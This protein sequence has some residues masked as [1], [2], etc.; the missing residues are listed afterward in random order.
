M[1][2]GLRSPSLAIAAGAREDIDR[3]FHARLEELADR[4]KELG[5]QKESDTTLAFV[6]PR[7]PQRSYYFYPGSMSWA[8]SR[9]GHAKQQ[10]I[11]FWWKHF[12]QAREE[13]AAALFEHAQAQVAIDPATTYAVLFEVCWLD[14]DH[15]A[16]RT[17]LGYTRDGDEWQRGAGRVSVT[18]GRIALKDYGF[19]AKQYW[20]ISS[21]H[22]SIVTNAGEKKGRELA[23]SLEQ[24]HMVWHQAFFDYWGHGPTLQRRLD[25]TLAPP[26]R[27]NPKRH[28]VVY[29][30]SREQYVARLSVMEPLIAK[31]IG[32][33][34][35]PRRSSYLYDATV[36]PVQAWRHEVGHQLFA[37]TLNARPQIGEMRDFWVV[38]GLALYLESY[39]PHGHYATL[40][41][42]VAA[43]LQFARYRAIREGFR[44]P[45]K[46][47]TAWGRSDV[48]GH[49]RL[50]AL[51]SQFAG[52]A[53]FMMDDASGAYRIPLIQYARDTYRNGEPNKT[54]VDYL[55]DAAQNLDAK[56]LEYLQVS[57]RLLSSA[58]RPK[59]LCLA[60]SPVT[61]QG[62]N[63]LDVSRLEW[64][65]LSD[66]ELG[67]EVVPLI[68]RAPLLEQLSLERTA[69]TAQ[70]LATIGTL[71]ALRELELT[72]MPLGNASLEPLSKLAR[73][74]GL[75][76][77]GTGIGD[78]QL[79]A[80]YKLRSLQTLDIQGCN[81]SPAAVAELKRQLPK[82]AVQGP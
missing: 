80:L 1:L 53:H 61:L 81:V 72:G 57:D 35:A 73:L 38:E 10:A 21:E 43:R 49:A 8:E 17:V 18:R 4:C 48:Q 15:V 64:L 7:V 3:P 59:S 27:R 31:T 32:F 28:V 16:A 79:P 5:L 9:L 30:S 26:R 39:D 60:G 70:C 22:F 33:Y 54:L 6:V 76:L 71:P 34:L 36:Q 24:F 58:D 51:Y 40:G 65:D 19:T 25:K 46:E 14:P 77:G 23:A 37:E 29:F 50:G 69:I 42:P 20:R 44:V 12:R 66:T 67:D 45:I 13:Y 55:G 11:D 75:W 41:G 74:E 82:A 56:Y 2:V 68:G 47:M 78:Q 63:K 62:L 52:I